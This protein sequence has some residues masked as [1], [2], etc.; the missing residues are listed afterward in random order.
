MC[1]GK[2]KEKRNHESVQSVLFTLNW[3]MSYYTNNWV[4]WS[5][6]GEE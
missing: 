2:E 3:P 1:L 4:W 6:E 5:I